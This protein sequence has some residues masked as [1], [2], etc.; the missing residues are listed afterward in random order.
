TG[1]TS[2]R[3]S[4]GC[5]TSPSPAWTPCPSTACRPSLGVMSVAE[6]GEIVQRLRERAE[7][8][9]RYFRPPPRRTVSESGTGMQ[10]AATECEEAA[11]AIERLRAVLRRALRSHDAIV[12]AYRAGGRRTPGKAIDDMHAVKAAAVE[13]E[14]YPAPS[15]IL[16]AE[17][18]GRSEGQS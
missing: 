4:G 1:P 2:R 14:C 17:D 12:A 10:F 6:A 9:R 5:G 16:R 13:M 15:S 18:S 3:T 8:W 7:V 11:D